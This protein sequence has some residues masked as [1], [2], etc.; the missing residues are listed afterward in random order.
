MSTRLLCAILLGLLGGTSG[1]GTNPNVR[2]RRLPDGRLQVDGPLAGPYKTKD[3]LAVNACEIMTSQSGATGGYDGSEYCALHYFSPTENAYYLSYL[4]DIK[5]NLDTRGVKS[6]TVPLALNDPAHLDAIIIGID[7]THP[8]SRQ[9]SPKDLK[10]Q[11]APSR[12]VDKTT[13]RVFHRELW[14][15][16]REKSGEC[17]IY[18]FDLV[19]R[20]ISALRDGVWVPIGQTQDGTGNIQMFEGK[21]WLP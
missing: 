4:S 6:C 11:W 1:C 9:L 15:F 7:H 12:A 13:G 20:T 18:G 10:V 5:D 2:A 14:L 8:H 19:T 3:E 21:D 16:F 17:R